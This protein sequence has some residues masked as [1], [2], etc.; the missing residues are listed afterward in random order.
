MKPTLLRETSEIERIERALNR[1]Y[2]AR[3]SSY[4][5]LE[6]DESALAAYAEV[7]DTYVYDKDGVVLDL[8]AG[9]W[10]SPEA[11]AARGFNIV[12]GLDLFPEWVIELY[13][14]QR[15]FHNVRIEKYNGKDLP[16]NDSTIRVVASLCV[17]EHVVKVDKLLDEIDRVL[18]PGGMIVIVCPNW[19]GPNN[20][21]RAIQIKL[22]KGDRYWQYE[23]LLDSLFGIVRS[24]IWYLQVLFAQSPKFLYI[25]P[26]MTGEDISF[27]RGDDDVVHLCQPLSFKKYFRKKGYQLIRYN[28]RAGATLVAR[29]FNTLF[30]SLATT[31]LIIAKKPN[32][33]HRPANRES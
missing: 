22:T 26:R 25:Y 21:I 13:E 2:P 33:A 17:M 18:M 16:F 20:A 19:S 7:I 11:I 24:F 3:P 15:R 10:R 1:F 30:P 29:I 6:R 8:G 5:L 28:R 14:Q 4:G 27:E 32:T 23:T 9:T 31:N 12:I